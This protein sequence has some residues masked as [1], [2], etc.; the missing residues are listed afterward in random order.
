M[1]S[2]D[3]NNNNITYN[4]KMGYWNWKTTNNKRKKSIQNNYNTKI[5]RIGTPSAFGE[6][7]SFGSGRYVIK[8]MYLKNKTD[9]NI[10]KNE[11]YTGRIKG[12]EEVG[13]RIY[14]WRLGEDRER[15][16]P[17]WYGEYI[18]DHLT[19]GEKGVKISPISRLGCLRR[20]SPLFNMTIRTIIRFWQITK[21]FHGDLHAGNMCVITKDSEIKRVMIYDYGAHFKS[22]KAVTCIDTFIKNMQ[23]VFKRKGQNSV[24]FIPRVGIKPAMT[25][26]R[27]PRPIKEIVP[28]NGQIVRSNINLLTRVGILRSNIRKVMNNMKWEQILGARHA[29]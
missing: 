20:G 18:M 28:K 17:Q 8:R 3:N 6:V 11:I 27:V 29:P 14:A 21:G 10:F 2:P 13:P 16:P 22:N 9:S 26:T 15:S 23:N 25:K 7:Y 19:L 24:N 1:S 5:E 4:N 12:I